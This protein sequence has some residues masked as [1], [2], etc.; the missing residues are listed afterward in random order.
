M[1]KHSRNRLVY[2]L[3]FPL[4]IFIG[5]L[6]PIYPANIE[7][8]QEQALSGDL[9]NGIR[10]IEVTAYKYGFFPN[11]I[12]VNYGEKV[13]LLMTAMDVMH[14]IRISEFKVDQVL[15]IG[16]TKSIEFTASKKGTFMVH[17]SVYCGPNHGTQK[18]KVIVR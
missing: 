7:N 4:F 1:I 12:V 11:P 2:L 13:K 10:E 14:G 17:C 3:S 16:K 6:S 18:T 5:F 8:P 9:R 15:P